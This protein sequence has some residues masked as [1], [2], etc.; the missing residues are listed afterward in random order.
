[1]ISHVHDPAHINRQVPH[2]AAV[3]A[4]GELTGM[5]KMCYM[6]LTH[7]TTKWSMQFCSILSLYNYMIGLFYK[8]GCPKYR[9]SGLCC[10]VTVAPSFYGHSYI[11]QRPD[12]GQA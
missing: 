12:A 11:H 8:H 7:T 3:R 10:L 6:H 9:S 2:I 5:A 1:M 4:N